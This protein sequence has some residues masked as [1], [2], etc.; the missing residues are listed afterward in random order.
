MGCVLDIVTRQ[1]RLKSGLAGTVGPRHVAYM[2]HRGTLLVTRYCIALSPP[3]PFDQRFC[4][5]D[6]VQ[7]GAGLPEGAISMVI[8]VGEARCRTEYTCAAHAAILTLG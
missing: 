2:R 3:V 5:R 8:G 6:R 7:Y 1:R 4:W